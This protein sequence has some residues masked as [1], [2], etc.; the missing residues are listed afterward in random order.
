MWHVLDQPFTEGPGC[1]LHVVLAPAS[2]EPC[3][4]GAHSSVWD[5]SYRCYPLRPVQDVSCTGPALGCE[6]HTVSAPAGLGCK[7]TVVSSGCEVYAAWVLDLLEQVLPA[8]QA[9]DHRVGID[10][11]QSPAGWHRRHV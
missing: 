6:L 8:A 1:M 10:A 3:H 5:P 2:W 4:I 7:C 9:P 11:A